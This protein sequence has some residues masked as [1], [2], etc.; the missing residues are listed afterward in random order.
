MKLLGIAVPCLIAAVL[1]GGCAPKGHIIERQEYTGPQ[2]ERPARIVVY[3]FESGPGIRLAASEDQLGA[4]ISTQLVEEISAMGLPA[5]RG[6][7]QTSINVG[8][9]VLR[10]TLISA[11]EGNAAERVALG[12]GSGSSELKVR[13]EGLL[14][15][16]RGLQ[17]LGSGVADTAGGKSPGT[18]LAAAGAVAT[19]NPAGLIVS[20]G[21]KL[22]GE[23]SGGSKLEGRAK[24]MAKE[25]AAALKPK[26]QQQG[27]L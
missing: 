12:F 5:E 14:M 15:T 8:D 1:L 20:G 17:K 21:M 16:E 6:S 9:V 27:W 11:S 2:I 26:F 23:A 22:Y 3:D 7:R 24:D 25:I 13:V 10:G 18:A 19:A 4:I